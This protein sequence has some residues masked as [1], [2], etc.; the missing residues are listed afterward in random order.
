MVKALKDAREHFGPT[1]EEGDR[2]E[3]NI[4]SVG[5][6]SKWFKDTLGKERYKNMDLARGKCRNVHGDVSTVYVFGPGVIRAIAGKTVS[7]VNVTTR[8]MAK[9]IFKPDYS[10]GSLVDL[11]TGKHGTE[12]P[13]SQEQLETVWKIEKKK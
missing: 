13:M 12:F 10:L 9:Y 11:V 4:P 7:F 1:N 5:N 2:R 6:V 8:N 3:S